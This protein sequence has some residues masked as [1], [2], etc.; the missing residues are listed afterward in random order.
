LGELQIGYYVTYGAITLLTML[1]ITLYL[2]STRKIIGQN[3]F[4]QTII[5]SLPHPFYV[6]DTT[7]YS[8]KIA[9]SL[10]APDNKWQG[11]T[12]YALTH[13]SAT[14]CAGSHTCPLNLVMET[15]KAVTLEHTHLNLAGEARLV[16]VHGC[17]IFDDKGNVVQ[18][19]EYSI[20]ITDR[21]LAEQERERLITDLQSALNR[22]KQLSGFIP[23]CASC[24]NIRNDKGYW[25]KIEQYISEHSDAQFSHSIC[26]D[27]A[28]KLYPELYPKPDNDPQTLDV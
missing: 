4:L 5:E 3:I 8:L 15:K 6:V 21:K 26:L 14:P 11:G 24:K 2:W 9:N 7:D 1:L 16:E 23:I 25:Q 13:Q 22:V 12:C 17:P 28:K 19:I 18:M 10:V 20:D 27:C